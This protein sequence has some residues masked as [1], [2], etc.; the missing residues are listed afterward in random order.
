MA[1]FCV[2]ASD[3]TP[4]TFNITN[5]I[6]NIDSKES[7]THAS[8]LTSNIVEEKQSPQELNVAPSSEPRRCPVNNQNTNTFI[9][10]SFDPSPFLIICP[11][12]VPD[13]DPSLGLSNC[14]SMFSSLSPI[15]DCGWVYRTNSNPNISQES[16]KLQYTYLDCYPSQHVHSSCIPSVT[17]RACPM[18]DPSGVSTRACPMIDPG[19]Y[20]SFTPTLMSILDSGFIHE[21]Y[22]GLLPSLSFY[23]FIADYPSEGP[24]SE[25]IHDSLSSIYPR[26]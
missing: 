7:L 5:G 10:P 25:S 21:Y 18:I 11:S 22:N 3:V 2:E 26:D 24:R 14:P 20:P 16:I 23:L 6:S 17:T 12:D 8:F 1:N 9:D 15:R 19:V 4:F 13:L